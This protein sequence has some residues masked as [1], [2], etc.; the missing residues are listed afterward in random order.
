[1]TGPKYPDALPALKWDDL[2]TVLV[3]PVGVGS[4]IG[5]TLTVEDDR[6][7]IQCVGE[8][9]CKYCSREH[10]GHIQDGK[11]GQ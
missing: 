5:V 3:T 9:D 4:L 6:Q 1:M 10:I 8:R 2:V 11:D 7:P